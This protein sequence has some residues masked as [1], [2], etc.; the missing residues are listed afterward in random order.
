MVLNLH[1]PNFHQKC[2]IFIFTSDPFFPLFCCIF[3]FV[4]KV[5]VKNP[6]FAGICFVLHYCCFCPVGFLLKSLGFLFTISLCFFFLS[7]T[8]MQSLLLAAPAARRSP[9]GVRAAG[10][11]SATTANSCGIPTK[12]ATRHVS[13][14]PR[15]SG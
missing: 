11:S 5:N 12:H 1:L 15:T 14:E 8:A 6:R 13:R 9:V 4:F 10:R 2:W 7:P 3:L